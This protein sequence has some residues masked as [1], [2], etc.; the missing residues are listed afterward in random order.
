[1]YFFGSEAIK[2]RLRRAFFLRS[3]VY[4]VRHLPIEIDA[5]EAVTS[6][7][8][9]VHAREIGRTVSQFLKVHGQV[10]QFLKTK[11]TEIGPDAYKV[12]RRVPI[13]SGPGLQCPYTCGRSGTVEWCPVAQPHVEALL[14]Q[15]PR[16][17]CSSRSGEH[18][19][20][21]CA[22]T[23]GTLCNLS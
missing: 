12:G 7:F 10:S 20:H 9:N 14:A 13:Y 8:L 17:G 16:E 3:I 1:M 5:K 19:S 22:L 21:T 2:T 11:C 23:A 6:R 15:Q 4:T 18:T